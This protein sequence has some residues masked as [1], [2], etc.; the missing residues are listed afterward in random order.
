MSKTK[1]ITSLSMILMTYSGIQSIS[2]SASNSCIDCAAT[3]GLALGTAE[4]AFKTTF[5]SKC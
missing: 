1:A 4:N 2:Y 5:I 3:S